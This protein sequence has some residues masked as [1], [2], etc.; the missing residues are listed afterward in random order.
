[1]YLHIKS[2]CHVAGA[3]NCRLAVAFHSSCI[4][5][6]RSLMNS[7]ASCWLEDSTHIISNNVVDYCFGHIDNIMSQAIHVIPINKYSPMHQYII[8]H[9][10][11]AHD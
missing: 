4:S 5:L 9:K 10:T 8:S 7:V 2:P 3:C 1:M 6:M 11:Q